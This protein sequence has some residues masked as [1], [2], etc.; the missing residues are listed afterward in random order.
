MQITT[1]VCAAPPNT[2]ATQPQ[3]QIKRGKE[4]IVILSPV[5][6]VKIATHY[7]FFI[8]LLIFKQIYDVALLLASTVTN[9]YCY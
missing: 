7:T 9:C 4:Q 5:V 1:M 8:K 2:S 6:I 3:L